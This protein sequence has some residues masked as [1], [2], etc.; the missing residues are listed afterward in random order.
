[1]PWSDFRVTL[2]EQEGD[3]NIPNQENNQY[4]NAKWDQRDVG[5]LIINCT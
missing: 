1:M 2:D 3:D 5:G 4:R